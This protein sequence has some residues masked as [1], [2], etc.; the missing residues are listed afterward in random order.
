VSGLPITLGWVAD[1]TGGEI[2]SGDPDAAV[3]AV[4]TDSRTL[5]PG[6]FFVALR[7][8]RFDGHR[9]VAQAIDRGAAGV[10]VERG[11]EIDVPLRSA[12]IDVG[13]TTAALQALA[14]AVRM[15]VATRV[16][17]ITGSAGKTTTK[18]AIAVLL[19]G[20]FQV[21]KNQGNLN[22]HIGLPIS[23]MQL[24]EVPDVAVMEL[25]MNHAGEIGVLVAIAKPDVRVWTNVG[26]AHI[27]F[28][29]SPDALADAKAEILEGAAPHDV[30]VC[31]ADDPHVMER[32]GDFGGRTVT[33]GTAEGANVR[34]R[35][36][37][38]LGI[39]GTRAIVTTPAGERTLACPLLGRGN[40]FNVLAATAV[41]LEFGISLDDVG[42]AV[43]GLR[44]S[45]RRGVVHRLRHGV[46]LIDDSYNSS[47]SALR[48][49]LDAVHKE[50]RALRKVAVLGEMLEL[51]AYGPSL[52]EQCGRAVALAG[53][54]VLYAIGGDSARSLVS[55]ALSGGL[56]PA[57]VMYLETSEQAAP[58]VASA[59][60]DRDL[61]LVKG[62]RGIGT[63]L[64]VDR[65]VAERG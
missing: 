65:I 24:R 14:H 11:V 49:A 57:N 63:D 20:R 61:V 25:G 7:G 58:L 31:N 28:F 23:L 60:R 52:H 39:D 43:R 13:D 18:D 12:V 34:A 22:N 5:G 16:V 37:D 6:D 40:L 47:P 64:I 38:E 55:G 36:I 3:G 53:V 50:T 35:H 2:R 48:A 10:M 26:D 19:S 4:S 42:Q 44:P 8:P 41:A 29:A 9:F 46:V 59:I 15:A 21:V 62:S 33:F 1:A 32:V 56:S 54:E 45:A 27:G 51:G 17:V 30:L